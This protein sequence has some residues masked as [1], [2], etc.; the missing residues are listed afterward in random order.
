[1]VESVYIDN[2]ASGNLDAGDRVWGDNPNDFAGVCFDGFDTNQIFDWEVV[3]AQIQ[4]ALGLMQ[5]S[6]IYTGAPQSFRSEPGTEP[7]LMIGKTM[8]VDG[9]GYDSIRW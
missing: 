2:N 8:I 9:E 5:P 1:M 7:D 4:A 6:I 3:A